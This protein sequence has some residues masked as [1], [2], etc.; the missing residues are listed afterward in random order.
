MPVNYSES[1]TCLLQVLMIEYCQHRI[2]N[3]CLSTHSIR[4]TDPGLLP[5]IILSVDVDVP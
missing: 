1:G 5:D 2:S 4:A 3:V